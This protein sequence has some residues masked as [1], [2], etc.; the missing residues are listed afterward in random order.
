MNKKNGSGSGMF[1]L[2]MIMA[3]FF[4]LLCSGICVMAFVKANRMSHL[5]QDTNQAVMIAESM[6]ETWKVGGKELLEEKTGAISSKSEETEKDED[7]QSSVCTVY[8]DQ[9]GEQA[10][11]ESDVFFMGIL[12]QKE[13]NGLETAEIT[14]IRQRDQRQ[15]ITMTTARYV[16]EQAE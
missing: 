9:K 16:P 11:A 12:S 3:V 10:A 14:V 13:K 2:E 1:M 5:A 7:S 6:A 4:F 15:L 8:L